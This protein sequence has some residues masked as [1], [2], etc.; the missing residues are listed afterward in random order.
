MLRNG[1]KQKTGEIQKKKK[2]EEGDGWRGDGWRN[3]LVSI[4]RRDFVLSCSPRIHPS[5]LLFSLP[6]IFSTL[7]APPLLFTPSSTFSPQSLF[8][9]VPNLVLFIAP[10]NFYWDLDAI[11]CLAPQLDGRETCLLVL[12]P[13]FPPS[14]PI[15]NAGTSGGTPAPVSFPP[16][17]PPHLYPPIRSPNSKRTDLQSPS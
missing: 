5:P 9:L 1:P 4:C 13:S 6:H 15:E 7:H 2:E 16:S 11:F 14:D 12:L 17:L 10:D 3:R 8:A